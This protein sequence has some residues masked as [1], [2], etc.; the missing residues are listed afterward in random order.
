MQKD[1]RRQR[2]IANLNAG[3]NPAQAALSAGY[4]EAYARVN[5]YRLIKEPA[6]Q[7]ALAA[8]RTSASDTSLRAQIPASAVSLSPHLLPDSRDTTNDN[9][10]DLE[11][12]SVKQRLFVDAL[13]GPARGNGT[14]AA[15]L[16]GYN[17]NRVTLASIASENLTKPAIKAA[18]HRRLEETSY[19]AMTPAEVQIEVARIARAPWKDFIEVDYND[20]GEPIRT[21]MQLRDKLGALK[22]NAKILRMIEG[23]EQATTVNVCILTESEREA[24][25]AGI[26]ARL[27]AQAAARGMHPA[28]AID[29]EGRAVEHSPA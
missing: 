24:K 5:V 11:N 8:A 16:S 1:D 17:G 27:E 2:L 14:L 21:K 25:L 29:I 28:A 19:L 10:D 7:A 12:L 13:L 3:M 9:A 15:E 20:K 22:L 23:P 26:F 6:F 18:I 4:S